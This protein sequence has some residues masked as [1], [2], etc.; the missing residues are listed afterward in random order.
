MH[1]LVSCGSL[2]MVPRLMI[3]DIYDIKKKKKNRQN[4]L[5]IVVNIFTVFLTNFPLLSHN[6]I[7]LSYSVHDTYTLTMQIMQLPHLATFSDS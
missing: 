6:V 4:S 3:V 2:L 7:F 1:V 5:F